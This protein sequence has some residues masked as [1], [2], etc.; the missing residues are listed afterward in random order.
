MRYAP[1]VQ[2]AS[3]QDQEAWLARLRGADGF[4]RA[5]VLLRAMGG[6]AEEEIRRTSRLSAIEHPHVLR[7]IELVRADGALVLALEAPV[8]LSVPALVRSVVEAGGRLPW[9]HAARIAADLARAAAALRRALGAGGVAGPGLIDSSLVTE[10]GFG[11]VGA[12]P[13]GSEAE[14]L[15]SIATWLVATVGHDDPSAPAALRDT[16]VR[17]QAEASQR[18]MTLGTLADGLDAIAASRGATHAELARFLAAEVP[19]VLERA[20]VARDAPPPGLS[21]PRRLSTLAQALDRLG[22]VVWGED[23]VTQPFSEATVIDP[24]RSRP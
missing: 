16:I 6:L 17:A 18:R 5:V 11:V 20:R 24:P 15:R 23:T 3:I 13:R 12:A 7:V 8:A 19:D 14:D 22:G 21:P 10:H 9:T 4:D 2:F 1:I